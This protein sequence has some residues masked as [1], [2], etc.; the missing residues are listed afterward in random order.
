MDD[1][2]YVRTCRQ[3]QWQVIGTDGDN[4]YLGRIGPSWAEIPMVYE[5]TDYRVWNYWQVGYMIYTPPIS[6]L[7]LTGI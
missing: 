1:N 4:V 7:L 3:N 5:P 6:P 2:Q